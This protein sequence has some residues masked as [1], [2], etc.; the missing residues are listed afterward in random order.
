MLGIAAKWT[1][2]LNAGF[3]MSW[4]QGV[5]V[6]FGVT[7]IFQYNSM[8]CWFFRPTPGNRIGQGLIP[9]GAE[10]DLALHVERTEIRHARVGGLPGNRRRYAAALRRIIGVAGEADEAIYLFLAGHLEASAGLVRRCVGIPGAALVGV[11]KVEV[12]VIE[13]PVG[14]PPIVADL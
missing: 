4:I 14:T 6:E 2:G 8:P 1:A 12:K 13:C 5:S 7:S 3:Q 10:P 9:H 11:E